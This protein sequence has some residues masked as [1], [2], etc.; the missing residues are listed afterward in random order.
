[1]RSV[2]EAREGF[3]HGLCRRRRRLDAPRSDLSLENLMDHMAGGSGLVTLEHERHGA[4]AFASA[5]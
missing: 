1:M 5:D 2:A 3:D 4:S